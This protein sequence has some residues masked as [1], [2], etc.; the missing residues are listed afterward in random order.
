[1]FWDR[2]APIKGC[3]RHRKIPCTRPRD[4]AWCSKLANRDFGVEASTQRLSQF[5]KDLVT[6]NGRLNKILMRLNVLSQ[7][8]LAGAIGIFILMSRERI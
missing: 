8:I 7:A 4:E 2:N 3:A 1:V 5:R 6:T